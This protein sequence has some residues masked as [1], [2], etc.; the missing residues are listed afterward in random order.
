MAEIVTFVPRAD[1]DAR[2]NLTGF[3]DVCRNQLTVFGADL[4]WDADRWDV[5]DNVVHSGKTNR[6]RYVWSNWSTSKKD[7]NPPMMAQ[8][9]LDFAKAYTRYAYGHRPTTTVQNRL[10]ALRALE[11]ALS[12]N[13]CSPDIANATADVFNRACTLINEKLGSSALPRWSGLASCCRIRQR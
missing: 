12:E 4:D 5:S 3:I 11:R 13:G 1:L 9:F 2:Q 10:N 6:I 7:R 8:P